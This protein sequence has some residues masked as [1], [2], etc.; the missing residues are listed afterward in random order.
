MTTCEIKKNYKILDILKIWQ[1]ERLG[2]KIL[3]TQIKL[4]IK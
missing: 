2:K 3:Q 4:K 1:K